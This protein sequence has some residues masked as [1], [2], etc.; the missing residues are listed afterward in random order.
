ME[1]SA[2]QTAVNLLDETGQSA[3]GLYDFLHILKTQSALYTAGGNLYTSSHPLTKQRIDFVEQHLAHSK[4]T[5]VPDRPDLMAMHRRMRGKLKG[6]LDPP[7]KTL[8]HYRPD[9]PRIEARYARSIALS[10]TNEVEEALRIIDGLLTDAPDDPFRHELKGDILR[11]AQR[12]P[13]AIESYETAIR[14]LPWAALIRIHLARLQVERNDPRQTEKALE[15]LEQ[16][17]RYERDTP[18][19]WRIAATAYGR[20]GNRGMTALA[21]AEEA[22]LRNKTKIARSNAERALKLLPEGSPGAF[23]AQD[24]LS[25]T[26]KLK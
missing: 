12:V 16:A 21:L 13:E 14:M 7:E 6:F 10:R 22:F 15:N 8:R 25:A 20:L 2:D 3:Q 5:N 26:E 1:Q 18:I 23:Q 9:D 24:I 19:V 17:L 11:E 4:F